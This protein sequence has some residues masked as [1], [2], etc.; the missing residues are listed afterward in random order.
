MI[1]VVYISYPSIFG[2]NEK[3]I[4]LYLVENRITEDSNKSQNL[5]T[6][7]GQLVFV[8]PSQRHFS[9]CFLG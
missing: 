2:C 8:T 6:K 4:K 9:F 5:F 3:E 1:H 7:R